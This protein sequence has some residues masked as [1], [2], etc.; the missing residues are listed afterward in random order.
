MTGLS[1]RS[2]I[3][4][5]VGALA[6]TLLTLVLI[7]LFQ[8]REPDWKQQIKSDSLTAQYP[9]KKSV[10]VPLTK[11]FL[12]ASMDF[13]IN[14][15]NNEANIQKKSNVLVSPASALF[16]LGMAGNG[17]DGETLQEFQQVLGKGLPMEELSKSY[18]TLLQQYAKVP[19]DQLT[20]ADSIWLQADANTVLPSFLE[21]NARYFGQDVYSAPS[22]NDAKEDINFWVSH[23]TNGLIPMLYGPNDIIDDSTF[24]ILIN[25]IYFHMGW[26]N[27]FNPNLT[28][29]ASYYPVPGQETTVPMMHCQ[30]S[31]KYFEDGGATGFLKPYKVGDF[32][33]LALLPPEGQTPAEYLSSLSGQQLAQ[34]L[35]RAAQR[36]ISLTMPKFQLEYETTL[37][38]FLQR[39]GM[40]TSFTGG[41]FSRMCNPGLAQISQV[42]QKTYIDLDEEGTTAA[43][44]TAVQMDSGAAVEA[45]EI[46]LDRPFFYA[47]LD[48][49]NNFPLFFGILNQP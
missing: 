44:V 6:A 48:T 9:P 19:S 28:R 20:V 29:D 33:F 16:A 11:E 35:D 25:T 43:A 49:K 32:C 13:G 15:L 17:A 30:E 7:L 31:M 26:E 41:N 1:K 36:E 12:T 39:A 37:N 22:L 40:N 24:M 46:I 27:E 10:S 4:I 38:D 45:T 23:Q 42:I 14:F 3:L 8:N 5:G 21:T 34:L 18:G 47:I 2:W